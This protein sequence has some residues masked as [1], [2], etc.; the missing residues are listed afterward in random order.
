MEIYKDITGFEGYYKISNLGN[1]FSVK[2]NLVMKNTPHKDGY[3]QVKLTKESKRKC[4]LLHRLVAIYF[5]ENPKNKL[6][7]NHIDSNRVNNSINNLE[8]VSR[9]ENQKHSS[10]L[11]LKRKKLSNDEVLFIRNSDI[12]Q[13]DLAL[14]YGVSE[15]TICRI[16]KMRLHKYI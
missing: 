15:P 6:E 10:L 7:V 12:K 13:K 9:T 3:L 1:V 8:W 5:I 2:R 16:K 4:F 11:G 14:K